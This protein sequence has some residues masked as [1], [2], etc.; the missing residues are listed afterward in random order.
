MAEEESGGGAFER[1]FSMSFRRQ[2]ATR[3]K[4]GASKNPDPEVMS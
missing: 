3:K 4:A 1:F 2:R